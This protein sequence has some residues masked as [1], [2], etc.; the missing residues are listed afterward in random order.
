MW[1]FQK[2]TYI[3]KMDEANRRSYI[4]KDFKGDY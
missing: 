2:K 3:C 1:V 4:Q